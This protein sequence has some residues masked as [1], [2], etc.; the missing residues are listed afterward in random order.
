MKKLPI[1]IQDFPTL[2]QEGYL[3]VDKTPLAYQLLTGQKGYFFSRPR[4]FGKSLLMS[5]LATI[6]KGQKE[7]FQGLHIYSSDY[8]WN[9]FPIIQL[10]FSRVYAHTE[11]MLKDSLNHRLEE[12]AQ[13]NGII[14]EKCSYPAESFSQLILALAKE[15]QVVIL[16]DEY[17]HPLLSNLEDENLT[18]KNREILNDF[19]SV[20]KSLG[21]WIRFAFVIGVSKFS[22][23]SLFS[24]MNNLIDITL[25]PTFAA[26]AGITELELSEYYA[27]YIKNTALKNQESVEEIKDKIKQWYNGYCFTYE[28]NAPKV[29]NPVSVHFF[30]SSGYLT[31]YWFSTATPTFA[32]E[33]IRKKGFPVID[34]NYGVQIG[35]GLVENHESHHINLI[36]LLFQTGY[37]TIDNYDKETRQY[38]L[39]FPNIEVRLS[40]F[41]HLLRGFTSLD[42]SQLAPHVCRLR[43]SLQKDNL[44]DFIQTLNT[45]FAEIPH[46][47]HIAKEAYYHS[48]IYL[49]LRNINL[50]VEP[51]VMTS[52][53]RL[54]LVVF[55]D[56]SIYLFEFKLHGTAEEALNQIKS[57]KYHHRYLQSGKR[58]TLVGVQLDFQQRRISSWLQ[59]LVC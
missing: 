33:M 8:Q 9:T 13:E 55:L 30:L 31:N 18:K 21:K 34:L 50:K 35:H 20:I 42:D 54:D 56:S 47:L 6:F 46:T 36:P 15:S 45:L 53:G 28:Q 2:I 27:S 40:F 19:F 32:I 12:A 59:E 16:I 41:D 1:G 24:G 58:I 10:D 26:L 43:D 22:K 57:K 44:E 29:Y 25:D 37:L 51:E 11:E 7:L 39:K 17:D 49:I 5:T 48:I 52:H 38:L 23:V 4:R 14:F 3:Y